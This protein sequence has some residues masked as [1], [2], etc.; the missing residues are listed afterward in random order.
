MNPRKR[1]FSLIAMVSVFAACADDPSDSESPASRADS[2]FNPVTAENYVQAET[3][4]NFALQQA[5]A[6]INTWT[7]NDRV[8]EENQT[9]IRSNADVM[10]S[11]GLVDVSEG[12]TLSIP[13][14]PSGALQLIH[15]MDE[16][17]LTH[18]V[19]YAGESVSVTPDDLTGGNYIYILART[20]ISDDMEESKAAQRS[21]VINA[22]S[23][24]PYQPKG[25]DPDEVIAFRE[26]LISEVTSGAVTVD[27]AKSVGA[28]LG[29]VDYQ[30]YYYAAAMGWGL[31]PPQ[32][33]QYTAFVNGQGS[34]VE[35]QTITFPKP[36]LDYENGG[37]FSLTTYNADSW[38]EGDNFYIGHKRMKE[39]DDGTMTID[40]NCD[41]PYSVTVGKG[42]NGSFRLYK[43]LDVQE[44]MD[45]VNHLMTIEIESK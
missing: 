20:Q 19:I 40:F 15:Y 41:T 4:W 22:S 13:E 37:F 29:D 42:W 6:Q 35:C 8:T 3:D 7:H 43:A 23:A 44:T 21:M 25:F 31:L 1:M 45:A 32:H 28:T 9:I 16:N 12:A 14:R 27:P 17:H 5:Q 24:K 10:Y 2:G 30:S 34:D 36:N 33:A 18:G 39:N 11:L 26:K 38:I